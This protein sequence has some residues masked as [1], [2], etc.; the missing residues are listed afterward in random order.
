MKHN[1]LFAAVCLILCCTVVG[2]A[3][4]DFKTGLDAYQRKEYQTA[5]KELKA[6]GGADASY[7]LSVMY[8]RGEGVEP[9]K[10][11]ALKWLQRSAEKGLVRAQYNLG[12]MYDKGDGVARDMAAAAKWYRRAAEKGH[13]QSQF[14]LGLMYTNGEGVEK[15]KQE[16]MKWL[17]K[18]AR[19]GHGKAR[20]LLKVM[21]E[22]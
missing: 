11:E 1:K 17:R 2:T 8:F 7:V 19:Q 18:A 14:N 10:T 5:L 3:G 20:K 6:D 9:N 22:K 15:D 13:A 21:S 16:A 12:M 4:A